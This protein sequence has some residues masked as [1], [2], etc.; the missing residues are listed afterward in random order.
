[1]ARFTDNDFLAAVE[2]TLPARGQT[3]KIA[4][5]VGCSEGTASK[6]LAK[7]AEAGTVEKKKRHSYDSQTGYGANL[8]GGAGA[9]IRR[10][11]TYR[12]TTEDAS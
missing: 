10:Y 4:A 6:R 5:L 3:Q 8:F 1:M 7:L 9:C 11:N 12:L 2:L